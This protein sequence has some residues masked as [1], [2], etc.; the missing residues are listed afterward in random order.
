MSVARPVPENFV[1]SGAGPEVGA[2]TFFYTGV[3]LRFSA[4]ILFYSGVDATAPLEIRFYTSP[5]ATLFESLAQPFAILFSI[6]FAILFSIPFAI[7]GAAWLSAATGTPFNMMSQIGLLFRWASWS[8]AASCCSTTWAAAQLRAGARRSH[9]PGRSRPDAG[10][11][12]GV[13]RTPSTTIIGLAPLALGGSRVGGG[14]LLPAGDHS[15]GRADLVGRADARGLALR[16]LLIEY[17]ALWMKWMWQVS[18]SVKRAPV[19]GAV[20][21]AG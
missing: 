19:E 8:T 14:V 18:G 1:D 12:D 21:A 16:R 2:R 15:H 10:D 3:G 11:P 7:P 4:Q 6:P 9:L 13:I 20:E 5:M 17:V